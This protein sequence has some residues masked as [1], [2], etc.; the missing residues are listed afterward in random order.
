[1]TYAEIIRSHGLECPGL[2]IGYK[3]AIA[4]MESLERLRA[5][6]EERVAIVENDACG[7]DALQCITGCTFGARRSNKT[8]RQKIVKH[9]RLKRRE[10]FTRLPN[11]PSQN[12]N[13][14]LQCSGWFL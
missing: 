12:G 1:M 9:P 14:G 4:A 13:S 10:C 6:N 11:I 5:E 8:L 2:A 7:V 3:M